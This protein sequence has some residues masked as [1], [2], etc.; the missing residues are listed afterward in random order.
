MATFQAK[1]RL[2]IALKERKI[3]KIVLMSS[4][5]TRNREFE[6]NSKKIEKIKKTPIWLLF[7]PKQ[8]GKGWERV[9]IKKNRSD[10]FLPDPEYRIP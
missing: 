10:E 3:K 1:K 9:K 5:Q 2:R 4:Y 6:K 7:K 8:I